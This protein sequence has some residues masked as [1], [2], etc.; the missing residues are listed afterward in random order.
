MTGARTS[1]PLTRPPPVGSEVHTKGLPIPP[2]RVCTC[3]W[4]LGSR[5]GLP[6]SRPG[7]ANIIARNETPHSLA[8]DCLPTTV[9]TINS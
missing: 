9:S 5:V 3:L 4:Q 2:T 6:K 7:I 8:D 1:S